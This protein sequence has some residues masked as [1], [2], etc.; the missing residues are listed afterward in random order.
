MIIHQTGGKKF[1]DRSDKISSQKDYEFKWAAELTDGTEIHMFNDVLSVQKNSFEKEVSTRKDELSCFYW[2][3]DDKK[4]DFN[5]GVS[6]INPSKFPA[7]MFGGKVLQPYCYNLF[8]GKE[9]APKCFIRHFV[10]FSIGKEEN[11]ESVEFNHVSYFIG[12]V[13]KSGHEFYV[14]YDGNSFSGKGFDQLV[15][16]GEYTV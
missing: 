4:N 3:G 2:H 6:F 12:F 8:N 16:I 10:D 7:F 11:K 1:T 15:K 13:A 9:F 5:F 14:T